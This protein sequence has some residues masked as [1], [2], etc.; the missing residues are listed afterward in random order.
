MANAVLPNRLFSLP[1]ELRNADSG[2][3]G[4]I[5][6]LYRGLEE[7]GHVLRRPQRV[8]RKALGPFLFLFRARPIL[9]RNKT[10]RGLEQRQCHKVPT[11]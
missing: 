2:T 9:D 1:V 10:S 3:T 7:T 11:N 8:P 4:K 5:P 6:E